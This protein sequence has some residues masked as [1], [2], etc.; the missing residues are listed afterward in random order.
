M[1]R[2]R[3][4]LLAARELRAH[5]QKALGDM[6]RHRQWAL[7]LHGKWR[8]SRMPGPPRWLTR[9]GPDHANRVYADALESAE[10]DMPRR[11]RR[12]LRGANSAPSTRDK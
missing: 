1:K 5:G 6:P 9:Y 4:Q 12:A 7:R 3:D 11:Y 10:R 2:R 8:R